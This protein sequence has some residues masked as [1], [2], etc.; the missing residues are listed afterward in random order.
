MSDIQEEQKRLYKRAEEN[1]IKAKMKPLFPEDVEMICISKDDY[2]RLYGDLTYENIELKD[3]ID[4][5][6]E[7]IKDDMYV[8]PNELYG[9]V[10]GEK[11]KSILQGSDKE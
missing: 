6:I 8:E 9:L 3:R 10:D 2:D 7:Y 4:K 1:D 5:A 11:V